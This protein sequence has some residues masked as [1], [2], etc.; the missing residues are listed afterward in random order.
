MANDREPQ[1]WERQDWDEP[2]AIELPGPLS[3]LPSLPRSVQIGLALAWWI[4]ATVSYK[5]IGMGTVPA[6]LVT[7]ISLVACAASVLLYLWTR[8]SAWRDLEREEFWKLCGWL[9][10]GAIVLT[11]LP[12]VLTPLIV[13]LVLACYAVIVFPLQLLR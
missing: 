9:A 11:S 6:A 3:L 2:P 5:A 8:R 1:D 12:G 13:L 7:L 4:V 10:I